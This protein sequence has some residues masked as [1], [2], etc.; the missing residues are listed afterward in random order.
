MS[1]TDIAIEDRANVH[2]WLGYESMCFKREDVSILKFKK[3]IDE[4]LGS[5]DEF[6]EDAER[7][8]AILDLITSKGDAEKIKLGQPLCSPPVASPDEPF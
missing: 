5:Y 2:G 4:M 8:E 7:T 3:Q 6:P 1:L